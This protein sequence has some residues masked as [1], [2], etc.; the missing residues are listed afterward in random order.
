M[1]RARKNASDAQDELFQQDCTAIVATWA[2]MR[3][4][5]R[6]GRLVD[7][8]EMGITNITAGRLVTLPDTSVGL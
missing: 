1:K 4:C 7:Y 8:N 5:A 6:F 2:R 3:A